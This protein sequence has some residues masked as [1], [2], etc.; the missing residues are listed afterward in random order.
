MTQRPVTPGWRHEPDYRV[1]LMLG[2][3]MAACAH[4]LAAWRLL[5]PSWRA[6]M[7]TTYAAASY[8]VVLTTLLILRYA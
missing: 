1:E 2:R 4:P 7:V 3:T 8:L 5:P 6:V